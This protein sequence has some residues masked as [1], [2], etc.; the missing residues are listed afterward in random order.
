MNSST[1][2]NLLK[3]PCSAHDEM[4]HHRGFGS[5]QGIQVDVLHGKFFS[6]YKIFHYFTSFT[7]SRVRVAS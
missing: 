4:Q 2:Q 7:S 1:L 6:E 5:S 3:Y